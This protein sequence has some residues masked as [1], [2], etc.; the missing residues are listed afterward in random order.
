MRRRRPSSTRTAPLF[1]YTTLFRSPDLH[2]PHRTTGRGAESRLHHRH[3]HP[4]HA[5]GRAR[6]RLHRLH[7][8]GRPG[9]ARPDGDDLLESGE[10][11]DRGLHYRQVWMHRHA[12]F[13]IRDRGFASEACPHVLNPIPEKYTEAHAF[14]NPHI[15]THTKGSTHITPTPPKHTEHTTR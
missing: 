12:G 7:V 6:V 5:A 10:A 2:Q 14:R 8:P 9:R 11:A 15:H 1:P 4:Q 13:G 3:R